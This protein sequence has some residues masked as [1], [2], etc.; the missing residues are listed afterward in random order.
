MDAYAKLEAAVRE[1][2]TL[3]QLR[4]EVRDLLRAGA[5]DVIIGSSVELNMLSTLAPSDYAARGVVDRG[6]PRIIE[7]GFPS[8]SFHAVQQVPTMGFGGVV[9]MAHRLLNAPHLTA[10]PGFRSWVDAP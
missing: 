2:P 6:G 9:A 3:A 4:S 5:L 8:E 10:A 1:N 7:L